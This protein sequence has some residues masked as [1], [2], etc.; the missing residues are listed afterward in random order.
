MKSC[1]IL[2]ST[3]EGGLEKH[4]IDLC[5]GMAE[6]G[7]EVHVIASEYFK[8]RFCEAVKV[9]PINMQRSR[10]NIVLLYQ[11]L[12]LLQGFRLRLTEAYLCVAIELGLIVFIVWPIQS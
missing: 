9:H 5:N 7:H 10:Y 12:T 1:E 4:T 6:S 2:A 8:D 11:L 3:G